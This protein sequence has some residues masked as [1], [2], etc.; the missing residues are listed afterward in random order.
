MIEQ[1]LERALSYGRKDNDA[2]LGCSNE[3]LAAILMSAWYFVRDEIKNTTD[4]IGRGADV[5][6]SR[7]RT[8]LRV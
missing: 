2:E 1:N 5:G 6:V 4:E 3:R 7:L 8:Q